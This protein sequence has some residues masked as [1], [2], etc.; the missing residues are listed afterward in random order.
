MRFSLLNLRAFRLWWYDWSYEL[1][2]VFTILSFQFD[3]AVGFVSVG[4]GHLMAISQ[5]QKRTTTRTLVHTNPRM[6]FGISYH[7]DHQTLIYSNP[8]STPIAMLETASIS[9]EYLLRRRC[10]NPTVELRAEFEG[11]IY[12]LNN[13]Y[14]NWTGFK[15]AHL[16]WTTVTQDRR[17]VPKDY[18]TVNIFPLSCWGVYDRSPWGP[19]SNR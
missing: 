12:P 17:I 13:I 18:W 11:V 5:R 19:R 9:I 4:L 7:D 15:V 3:P 1:F 8:I 14:P 10:Y 16:L 2:R 6:K